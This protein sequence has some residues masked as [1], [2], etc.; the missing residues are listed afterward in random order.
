[1]KELIIVR[2]EIDVCLSHY[3]LCFKK[4]SPLSLPW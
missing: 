2:C 4:S 1:V 3:T